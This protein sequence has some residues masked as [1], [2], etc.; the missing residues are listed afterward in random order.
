MFA[1]SLGH[2]GHVHD[3]DVESRIMNTT[4]IIPR[5]KVWML[6]REYQDAQ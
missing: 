1:S 2:R 5:W 6:I 3:Y 4:T